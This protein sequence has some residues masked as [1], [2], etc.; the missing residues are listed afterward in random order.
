MNQLCNLHAEPS[1]EAY[2]CHT[3]YH[4]HH[5]EDKDN[6]FPVN[7]AGSLGGFAG[8][9]PKSGGKNT[10]DIDGFDSSTHAMHSQTKY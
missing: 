7:T 10:M 3:F 2:F 4:N 9:I 8:M 5:S 6:G 1:K